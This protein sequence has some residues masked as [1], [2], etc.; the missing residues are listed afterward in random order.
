MQQ[1]LLLQEVVY[2]Q[3]QVHQQQSASEIPVRVPVQLADLIMYL[4]QIVQ[5]LR[6]LLQSTLA[7]L[8]EAQH[9]LSIEDMHQVDSDSEEEDEVEGEVVDEGESKGIQRIRELLVS[10]NALQVASSASSSA[11]SSAPKTPSFSSAL[12]TE[13]MHILD[14]ILWNAGPSTSSSTSAS[15][16][17]L[18]MSGKIANVL[19]RIMRVL[20]LLTGMVCFSIR[21]WILLILLCYFKYY[22]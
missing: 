22:T 14:I 1:A 7:A 12:L 21:E 10:A 9:L 8:I 20:V 6:D 5:L 15:I 2:L 18:S 19:S 17:A 16:A 4:T 13:R 3:V 11:S